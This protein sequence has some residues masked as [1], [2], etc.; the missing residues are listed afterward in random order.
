MVDSDVVGVAKP[1]PR[2]FD[3]ALPHFD[4]PTGRAFSTWRLG[5]DGHRA[6]RPPPVCI[7]TLIDPFDDHPDADFER[8]TSVDDIVDW[9]N[10]NPRDEDQS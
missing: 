6:R 3:F 1:D 7:P 5:H 8:I 2:I 9:F 10:S 4:V